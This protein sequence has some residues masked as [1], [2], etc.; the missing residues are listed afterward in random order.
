MSDLPP[1]IEQADA[2]LARLASLDL[3]LAEHVHACAL[4]ATDP[5]EVAD[6]ARAYQ[7]VS[8]SL[9]QTLALHAR[10][11]TDRAKAA[12]EAAQHEAWLEARRLGIADEDPEHAAI[13]DRIEDL[14]GALGR[15]ISRVAA[16]DRERHTELV[17][18]FD[19]EMDDWVEA[20]DF[21]D[22]DLDEHVLRA[23]RVLGLP[24]DLAGRWDELPEPTFFPDPAPRVRTPPTPQ[25]AAD[26]DAPSALTDADAPPVPSS[27]TG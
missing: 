2:M 3:S 12:R 10:L 23:C 16:G 24:E 1:V 4:A 9:R 27:D 14:H 8:R 7:R 15:V 11:K 5:D 26:P 21:L 25:E 22:R 17:H 19:R 20:D 6:L 13:E 18:R